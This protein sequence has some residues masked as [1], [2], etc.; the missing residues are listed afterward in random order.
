MSDYIL[1]TRNLTKKFK[2]QTAVSNVSLAIRRNTIFGLLGPNGAGKSTTLKMITGI[3]KA[4]SGE[5][6]F[7]NHPWSRRDLKDIGALI[8]SPAI[9][10][11][12]TAMENLDLVCA[13]YGLPKVRSKEVIDIID[14]KNAGKKEVK[15]FSTGMKQRL[16]LGM[17]LVNNPKLLILDEPTNGLDPIAIRE[18]RELIRSF[19]SRGVT[20]ILSSHMLSEVEQV[21][22]EIAI[23][24]KGIIG[25]SGEISK[26][27]NLEKQ[28][29]DVVERNNGEFHD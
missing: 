29:M 13:L 4:S 7:E 25:Y 3:M 23:I 11:N 19:P 14:L 27:A 6:L 28:F 2:D 24:S 12:L 5:I 16:G 9:Y 15:N 17:A 22:D 20:V 26:E 8:E 10:P 21:A 18:L 1:E